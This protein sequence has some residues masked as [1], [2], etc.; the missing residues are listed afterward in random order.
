MRLSITTKTA[1]DA[2]I[3]EFME[4]VE[5]RVKQGGFGESYGTSFV[6][7]E[8]WNDAATA[9]SFEATLHNN[10]QT[11]GTMVASNG[12]FQASLEGRQETAQ[13]GSFVHSSA[14]LNWIDEHQKKVAIEAASYA[15]ELACINPADARQASVEAY[16]QAEA[17]YTGKWIMSRTIPMVLV[18]LH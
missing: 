3:A 2:A 4:G 12:V 11:I 18:R 10:A 6:S 14:G 13:T 15:A 9:K 7:C 17:S 8:S 5:S 1:K 16:A